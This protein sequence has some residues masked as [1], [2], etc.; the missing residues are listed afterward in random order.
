MVR[1]DGKDAVAEA[2]MQGWS[3][4]E[5]AAARSISTDAPSGAL[6]Q[7]CRTVLSGLEVMALDPIHR[8][9]VYERSQK[10]L[11]RVPSA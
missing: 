6:F 4:A 1:G 8:A 3:A 2:F 5:R 10:E 7:K 9:M 11:W